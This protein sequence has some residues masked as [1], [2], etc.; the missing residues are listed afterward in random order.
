MNFCEAI[1]TVSQTKWPT[2]RG[3]MI[4]VRYERR[5]FHLVVMGFPLL[6]IFP[7]P[8]VPRMVRDLDF[9]LCIKI[10]RTIFN[11]RSWV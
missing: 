6:R 10:Y 8:T 3:F 2:S 11:V 5:S 9:D 7:H 4:H 1:S